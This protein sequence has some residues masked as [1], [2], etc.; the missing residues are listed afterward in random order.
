VKVA[1][2]DPQG[3]HQPKHTLHSDR[4]ANSPYDGADGADAIVILTEWD[5]FRA[6]DFQRLGQLM[7]RQ[8]LVDLRNIYRRAEVERF[9]FRYVSV[10]RPGED[11]AARLPAE[12]AE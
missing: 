2:H 4:F 9:G 8:V 5:A 11:S 1:A 6:L 7:R 10:G 12:A 3:N